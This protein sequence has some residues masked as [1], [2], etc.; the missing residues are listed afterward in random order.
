MMP[1]TPAFCSDLSQLVEN[2]GA[3]LWVH[4]HTHTSCDY[5]AGD[6]RGRLQPKGVSGRGTKR[7]DRK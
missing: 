3:V 5:M 6:A 4:G 2:C 7:R 1:V